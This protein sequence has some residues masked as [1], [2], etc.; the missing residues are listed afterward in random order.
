MPE[1]VKKVI[2]PNK[3]YTSQISLLQGKKVA[4]KII[5]VV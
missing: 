2:M 4:A 5:H 3:D 1:K